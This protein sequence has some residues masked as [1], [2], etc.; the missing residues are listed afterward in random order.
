MS[1]KATPKKKA[2]SKSKSTAR[3]KSAR[4]TPTASAA[5]VTSADASPSLAGFEEARFQN[6]LRALDLQNRG[7]LVKE[8]LVTHL[9]K[10]GLQVDDPRLAATWVELSKYGDNQ[11]IPIPALASR[12]K[13]NSALLTRALDG[14]LAVPEFDHF[15]QKAGA[16]MEWV[17]QNQD[18]HVADYIPQLK[19][20]DPEKLAVSVCTV[21]GQYFSTGD[22]EDYFCLQSTCKPLL[23]ALALEENGEDRVHQHIGREP[24][25]VSFNA[26]SLNDRGLPHNPMINAGA[27]MSCSLIRP[28]E[29]IADRFDYVMT[30]MQALAGVHAIGFDN[31]VYLS[32]KETGDRNFALGYFMR[33]SGAFP[34]NTELVKTLEFYFQCCSV[35][36][37]APALAGIAATMANAGVQPLT[38]KKVFSPGSVKN[39]LSLMLTCGMYDY[40]GEWAFLIGLPAKSGVCGAVLVIVPGVM[41]VC[42]WSP[43]L[44]EQGNSVR[45]IE[46]FKKL[47]KLFS[48]HNYDSVI[49]SSGKQDPRANTSESSAKSTVSLL[50]AAS[51]GDLDEIMHLTAKGVDLDSAD[52]DGRTAIHL[53][54]SEGQLGVLEYLISKGVKLDP[55]DRWQGTPLD[56]AEREGH[57]GAVQMLQKHLHK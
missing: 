15:T 41:G 48:V 37:N 54:A 26:L 21:D 44:N 29:V 38:G 7:S 20:V 12:A 5:A 1:R 39:C 53:A 2:A 40:S 4:A 47:V 51:T 56:D 8:T 6:A 57:E 11:E 32:E 28:R 3:R 45:G 49:K 14:E 17:R 9:H 36:V 52:Y 46:F 25:G 42:V 22:C 34:K 55:R 13:A 30:Q 33:E 24:S 10:C 43:R 27:I 50:F 23:Y 18:G 19:K 35:R 16:I 31:S